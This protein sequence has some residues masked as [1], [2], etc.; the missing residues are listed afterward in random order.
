M[1]LMARLDLPKT[2]KDMSNSYCF[3]DLS[4]SD[5]LLKRHT[6]YVTRRTSGVV[7]RC[8][9]VTVRPSVSLPSDANAA[10]TTRLS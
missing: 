2:S 6:T 4:M 10:G 5:V 7:N 3:S 9:D 8:Q 1:M